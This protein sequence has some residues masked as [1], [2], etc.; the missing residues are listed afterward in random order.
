[1]TEGLV[2]SEGTQT[3]TV[4]VPLYRQYLEERTVSSRGPRNMDGPNNMVGYRPEG[5]AYQLLLRI[6]E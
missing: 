3:Q 2:R 4:S 5:H 6:I 1:M